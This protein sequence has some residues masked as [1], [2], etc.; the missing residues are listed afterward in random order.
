MPA[1][2]PNLSAVLAGQASALG[3]WRLGSWELTPYASDRH[4]PRKR[5]GQHFLA[6]EWSQK[7]IAAIAPAAD[8]TFLEI[9]PGQGAITRQLAA[10]SKA[11]VAIEVDR[12]LVARLNAEAIPGLTVVEGDVL[13]VDFGALGLPPRTRV[14]GN[15]PYNI[16]SPILFKVLE[17]SRQTG[18]FSDATFMLQKEVADRLVARPGTKDYGLL[19]VFTALDATVTRQLTLPPGAFRPPPK[20][21]SA[22]VR[23]TFLPEV[24]RPAVPASFE[25]MVKALFAVRRKTIAN[26]LRGPAAERGLAPA[27]VIERAGLDVRAR[28]EELSVG[29]LLSLAAALEGRG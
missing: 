17:T 3:S 12:D 18:L 16:S 21:T 4:R 5:F 15:L 29:Q 7:L 20:V 14:A 25:G 1:M 11:V 26:G 27:D 10:R 23:L 24:Q 28:P 8:D 22:V 19:T 6:R 9:G 2:D 13:D